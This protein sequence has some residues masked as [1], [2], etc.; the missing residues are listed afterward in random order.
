[1]ISKIV[2]HFKIPN[3]LTKLIQFSLELVKKGQ[4]GG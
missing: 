4:N 1:M 2:S 3:K